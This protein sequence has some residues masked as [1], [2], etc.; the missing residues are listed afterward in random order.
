MISYRNQRPSKLVLAVVS[1]ALSACTSLA[2]EQAQNLE[3][4]TSTPSP[5]ATV[6]WFP[7]TSTATAAAL[8]TPK[9]TPDMKPGVGTL[10]LSDDFSSPDLWNTA[11][12]DQ[13]AVTVDNNRLT[14]AAQPG[15]APVASFRAGTIFSD[16]Y[17]EITARLSLCRGA[18][19]YGLLFR[20]PNNV[21]YYRF[22]VACNGTAGADRM[23]RGSPR[24]LQAP[25]GSGDVPAGAPGEVR[26]GVWAVG[27]EFRFFL[28]GRYQFTTAD[29]SYP[30]GGIGVFAHAAAD[31]PVTVAFS[32]LKVYSVTYVPATKP[33]P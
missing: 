1:L 15:I 16:L 30:S 25:I 7:V 21:A 19:D 18:D 17:V 32:D 4:E 14:I 5:T 6:V 3:P 11:V 13:A 2:G 12:S 24:V 29:N 33:T 9:P 27:S 20:A 22:A 10:V 8:P 31:T 26:L 28:N 23:S